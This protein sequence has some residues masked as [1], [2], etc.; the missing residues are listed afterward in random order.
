[1]AVDVSP[2][3]REQENVGVDANV[4]AQLGSPLAKAQLVKR[5]SVAIIK[6]VWSAL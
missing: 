5:F 6:N 3:H 2:E 1:M 4:D